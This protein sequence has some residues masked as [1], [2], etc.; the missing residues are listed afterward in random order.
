MA[1]N[2]NGNGGLPPEKREQ[3]KREYQDSAYS[4]GE[5]SRRYGR[6]TG[7][8]YRWA[9]ELK[10]K[11]PV[12]T[13]KLRATSAE[14]IRK[15]LE[16][17]ARTVPPVELMPMMPV[18]RSPGTIPAEIVVHLSD[19]H[20]G[21]QTKTFN[22]AVARDRIAELARQVRRSTAMLRN[23]YAIRNLRILG[24]GDWVH[25]ERI[26]QQMALDD[27]ESA[28]FSQVFHQAA[29]TVRDFILSLAPDFDHVQVD[30][31]RGNHGILG[32]MSSEIT[33]WD[34][35]AYLAL[36]ASLASQPTIT[37]N[38]SEDHWWAYTE[39]M[40]HTVLLI[41]GDQFKSGGGQQFGSILKRVS[42][43]QTTLP[44][45]FN[46]MA[47]GH[48]HSFHTVSQDTIRVMLNG[49]LVTDDEWSWRVV[50]IE[51]SCSQTISVVTERGVEWIHEVPLRH[52]GDR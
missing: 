32:K 14:E 2:G 1:S 52:V 41:H 43:W 49:A 12:H 8:I 48:F 19:L 39:I 21:R 6:S 9:W 29:P 23:E 40:G 17:A 44:K 22:L 38:V 36:K 7:T 30:C 37:V 15:S 3:F 10:V 18:E 5:L 46:I 51:G 35:A 16:D 33:N 34:T 28:V 24:M 42:S 4:L 47:M 50:G 13:Q 45:P 20:F 26:G 25:G 31:V 27:L 11:R